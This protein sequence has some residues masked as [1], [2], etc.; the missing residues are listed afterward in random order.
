[1][2]G[3]ERGSLNASFNVLGGGW[4]REDPSST[5]GNFWAGR[6]ARGKSYPSFKEEEVSKRMGPPS[7]GKLPIS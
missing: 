3:K 2:D 7:H 5:R 1:M 6:L 4:K